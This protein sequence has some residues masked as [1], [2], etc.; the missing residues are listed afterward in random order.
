M[1][2]IFDW[3]GTVS[4]STDKIVTCMQRAAE[5][6]GL[7]VLGDEL[8]RDIIGLG[9]PEALLRLYPEAEDEQHKHMQLNYSKHFVEADREPSA[10]YP[11]VMETLE[12][13]RSEGH[14]LAVATGKSRRGLDRIF[15]TLQIQN[16]FHASRCADETASKPHPK[17]LFEL[18]IELEMAPATAVMVGDTEYDMEMAQRANMASIAVSYGAHH[19]DRLRAYNPVLCVDQFKELA[20]WSGYVKLG[21]D[22]QENKLV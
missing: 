13:L 14:Q 9:L 16:F 17:M 8:I 5:D 19:I 4:D 21:L 15:E 12:Y 18:L 10:F 11:G 1:L 2:F 22:M 20:T 3:D 6:S 7:A